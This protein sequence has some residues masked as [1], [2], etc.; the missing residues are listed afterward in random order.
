MEHFYQSIPG[1]FSFRDFYSWLAR[2]FPYGRGVEVGSFAGR[3]AAYLA[4]ELHNLNVHSI[5]HLPTFD[6]IDT[7]EAPGIGDASA[8]L[9]R[10]HRVSH[11]TNV[12]PGDS[13]LSASRY[14]DGSLDWVY[15][16]ADHRYE[17]VRRDILAWLPK[18]KKG[19]MIAGHDYAA[20]P[21]FGVI[22]AVTEVFPRVEVW[23]GEVFNGDGVRDFSHDASWLGRYYP[24][25]C[26]RI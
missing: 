19:G 1:Y 2:R 17:A 4:V 18:V 8:V 3:S 10:L 15:I 21:T 23:R 20:Y 16:D 26:A 6:L 25:W 22:E 7:F 13:A 5:E 12:C 14:E 24:T 9:E 11:I